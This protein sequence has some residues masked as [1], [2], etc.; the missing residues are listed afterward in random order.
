MKLIGMKFLSLLFTFLFAS[1]TAVANDIE[2]HQSGL[3]GVFEQGGLIWGNAQAGSTVRYNGKTLEVPSS[4]VFTL[5]LDR[6][7]PEEFEVQWLGPDGNGRIAVLN[8]DKRAYKV[9]HVKGV[10]NKH[11]NPNPIHL[12]KIGA[13]SAAIKKARSDSSLDVD[14]QNGFIW[15]VKNVLTGVYGSRRT[16]NGEERSWHKGTDIAA[17]TGTPIQAP[18]G[19]KVALALSDSF[20]NGNLII[21]DHGHH[22]YTVYAHLDTMSVSTGDKVNQGHVIG[23]VGATGRVTGPHLHWGLYWHNTA[24]DPLLLVADK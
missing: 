3:M 22:V 5:G 20:F 7:A 17:P 6:H 16:F 23:T 15:P 11:V 18:A 8:I 13:D 2:R 1:H 24:L 14:F 9:Q 19:G 12:E 21:L 10:Q 4:G